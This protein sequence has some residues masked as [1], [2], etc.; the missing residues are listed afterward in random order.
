MIGSLI[1]LGLAAAT[2]APAPAPALAPVPATCRYEPQPAAASGAALLRLLEGP[3]P[4][5]VQNLALRTRSQGRAR[6]GR[7]VTLVHAPVNLG[8]RAIDYGHAVVETRVPAGFAI[9][10]VEA[11]LFWDCAQARSRVTC[12]STSSGRPGPLPEITIR[13]V[14]RRVGSGSICAGIGGGEARE[15]DPRDN[16]SCV[17]VPVRRG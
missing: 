7:P 4:A 14:A 8:S 11:P 2:P 6:V 5:P 17:T 10:A 1:F 12:A 3:V 15:S 13:L 9:A 16:R